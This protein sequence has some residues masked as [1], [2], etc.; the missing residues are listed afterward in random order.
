MRYAPSAPDSLAYKLVSFASAGRM[1]MYD[2]D[3]F[4]DADWIALLDAQGLHPRRHDA[5]AGSV[6][7]DRIDQHLA[8]LRE[9]II[10]GV[11]TMPPH[12]DYLRHAHAAP[13]ARCRGVSAPEPVRSVVIVGGGT[14]GWMAAAALSR[15]VRTG[16][17]VTLVRSDTIATVGVGEATI[18][19]IRNFNGLL[20]I[21]ENDFLSKTQGD[22]QA[23]HR[24]HRLD[25]R[26]ASLH[27]SLRRVRLRYRG[28]EVPSFLAEALCRGQGE[29]DRG[30]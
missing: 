23:R 25:P 24:F 17:S 22:N 28:R 2:D 4:E 10:A 7:V 16:V 12:G 18:P 13:A 9:A 6:P 14:A 26:G 19:P 3:M 30:L 20:G 21:D 15:L 27:A 29:L 1:P 8:W 5:L 11:K